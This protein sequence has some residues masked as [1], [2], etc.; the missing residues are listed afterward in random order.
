MLIEVLGIDTD[1]V[2]NNSDTYSMPDIYV[3]LN[4]FFFNKFLFSSDLQTLNC[5]F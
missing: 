4:Y 1:G 2:S 5:K 3:K